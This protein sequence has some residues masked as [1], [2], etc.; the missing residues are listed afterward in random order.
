MHYAGGGQASSGKKI[1]PGL[2]MGKN[3]IKSIIPAS[4]ISEAILNP[5]KKSSYKGEEII[6]PKVSLLYVAGSNII[7]HHPNTNEIIKAFK[8]LD[9]IIVQEPWWTPTAKYADIVLPASTTLERDDI[10]F[11][12]SYSQDYVY[13]MKKVIDNK[14]EAKADYDIF[15][16]IAKKS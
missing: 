12:G 11:G 15:A 16:L 2:S 13:A 3:P 4:R 7:G 8:T 6:F 9:T 1:V 10:T 14:F 5:G